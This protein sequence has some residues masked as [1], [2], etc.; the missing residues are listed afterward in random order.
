VS[1]PEMTG[2]ELARSILESRPDMPI[3]ITGGYVHEEDTRAARSIGA[4]GVI[5]KSRLAEE[6]GPAL[7]AML[8][9]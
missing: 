2:F 5:P 4:W 3:L 7:G 8:G 1:M 9:G 6:L